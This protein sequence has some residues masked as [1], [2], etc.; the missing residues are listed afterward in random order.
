MKVLIFSPE[1]PYTGA[2]SLVT[3]KLMRVLIN[4]GWE[5]NMIF[6]ETDF[7]YSSKG[8]IFS[9]QNNCYCIENK[10]IRFLKHGL[11]DLPLLKNIHYLDSL[12]WVIKAFRLAVKLNR[13][14]QF[15]LIF[16]SNASIRPFTCILI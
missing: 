15:D 7:L 8:D 14:K 13:T 9:I 2:E 1:K 11:K 3:C 6:H 16:Q 5:V 12:L 10:K 4:H